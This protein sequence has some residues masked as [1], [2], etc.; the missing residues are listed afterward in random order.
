MAIYYAILTNAGAAALAAR[1]TS[2]PVL[3]ATMALGDGDGASYEPVATQTALVNQLAEVPIDTVQ[4]DAANANWVNIRSIVPLDVGGFTIREVG[5]KLSDGTLFAVVKYPPTVKPA[6]ESGMALE[7]V[8][9]VT[10]VISSTDDIEVV[11]SGTLYASQNYVQSSRDFYAVISATTTAP[12]G[13]PSAL[14]CY[15]IPASATGAWAGLTGK[16]AVWFGDDWLY[17]TPRVGAHAD[18]GTVLLRYVGV[19]GWVALTASDT[20][21]GLVELATDAETQAGTDD[22]RAVTPKSLASRTAT[23]TRAG[24]VELATDAETQAGTDDTRAVTPKSLD[25]RTATTTRAGLVELATDD[26]A[27]VGVDTTRAV[28]PRGVALVIGAIDS[29]NFF[30][31]MM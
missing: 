15:L 20:K 16:I 29:D 1:T 31:G 14:D 11:A 30:L 17:L 26:E 4:V 25:A 22:T 9:A 7:T 8:I 18:N 5:L 3:L 23:A 6:P 12:P 2:A 24:I 10:L 27:R 19:G 21:A 28:T 13:A